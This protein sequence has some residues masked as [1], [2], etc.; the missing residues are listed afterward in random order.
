[1][2]L[3]SAI[4]WRLL[5]RSLPEGIQMIRLQSGAAWTGKGTEG[6]GIFQFS[7]VCSRSEVRPDLGGGYFALI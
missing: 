5:W 6:L 2:V 3:D 1:V 4:H 7:Q